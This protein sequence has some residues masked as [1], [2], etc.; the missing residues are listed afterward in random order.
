[1]WRPAEID[2]TDTR[3]Q[4]WR[5]RNG[6]V[7]VWLAW[8]RHLS[9]DRSAREATTNRRRRCHTRQRDHR[10]HSRRI[11]QRKVARHP[12]DVHSLLIVDALATTSSIDSLRG[13]ELVPA[14]MTG[15]GPEENPDN[16]Q[17]PTEQGVATESDAQ[18][19]AVALADVVAV[20]DG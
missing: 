9:I 10:G 3:P 8:R 18:E 13:Y 20:Q 4:Q 5:V 14:A 7:R 16:N 19:Q 2:R 11:Q 17:P 6:L 15:S 12:A 1:M